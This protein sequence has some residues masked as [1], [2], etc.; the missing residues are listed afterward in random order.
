M[1]LYLACKDNSGIYIDSNEQ[2][3]KFL[4]DGCDIYAR[5][6]N[7]NDTLIGTNGEW[8]SEKPHIDNQ[9]EYTP[10]GSQELKAQVRQM[11]ADLDYISMMTGVSL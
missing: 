2:L 7:N 11:G 10:G 9:G 8:I 5:D 6:D 3:D 1:V 4:R